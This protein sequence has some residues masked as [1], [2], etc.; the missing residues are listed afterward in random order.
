MG[1]FCARLNKE[2]GGAPSKLVTLVPPARVPQAPCPPPPPHICIA[3]PW[4]RFGRT[5]GSGLCDSGKRAAGGQQ[6]YGACG[7]W[8]G[9]GGLRW[10]SLPPS[11]PSNV[12]ES[13]RWYLFK[14]GVSP[15]GALNFSF[16]QHDVIRIGF[17]EADSFLIAGRTSCEST[18]CSAVNFPPWPLPSP[19]N[20]RGGRY[21]W[22]GGRWSGKR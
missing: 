8:R 1:A 16:F 5:R 22:K 21:R 19:L 12:K 20:Q 18:V 13:S 3:R 11:P 14:K 17:F 4:R 6:Q 15:E 9:A 10:Q 2:G 7:H